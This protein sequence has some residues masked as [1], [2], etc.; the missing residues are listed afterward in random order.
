MSRSTHKTRRQQR[1]H[2]VLMDSL[3]RHERA[4]Q[5][6]RGSSDR[7]DLEPRLIAVQKKINRVRRAARLEPVEWLRV[8]REDRAVRRRLHSSAV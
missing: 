8:N 6:L 1:E 4:W 5:D 2:Q 3:A 7:A